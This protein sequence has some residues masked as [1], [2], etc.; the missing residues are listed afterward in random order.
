[1]PRRHRRIHEIFSELGDTDE[2]DSDRPDGD[3]AAS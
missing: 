1:L 2:L 3:G